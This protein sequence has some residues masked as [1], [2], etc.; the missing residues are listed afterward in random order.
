MKRLLLLPLL[1]SSLTSIGQES[2]KDTIS[3]Q[4]WKIHGRFNFIFN[5]SSFSNWSS[6]GENTVAGNI[7]INYDFNYKKKNIN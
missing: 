6:G 3:E 1:L 7:N 2:K 4:Q 5:Q